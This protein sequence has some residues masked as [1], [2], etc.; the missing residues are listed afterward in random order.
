MAMAL[1]RLRT[2][3]KLFHW[4]TVSYGEHKALD[5]LGEQLQ[6]LNDRW[7][8]SYQGGEKTRVSCQGFGME[9]RDWL[10]GLPDCYLKEQASYISERRQR[11][12][13]DSS[14]S[15]LANILDEIVAAINKAR[16]ML[17]LEA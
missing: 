4:Q 6:A 8:E 5:W 14:H 16:Y 2:Q 17:S 3:V 7:V 9:L 15:Y 12:W 13:S 1:L 11:H 10:P